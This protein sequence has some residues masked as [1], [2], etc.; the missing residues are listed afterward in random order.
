MLSLLQRGDLS[1]LNFNNASSPRYLQQLLHKAA[2][3]IVC[4]F[5]DY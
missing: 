4:G 5:S 1:A 2:G 3:S